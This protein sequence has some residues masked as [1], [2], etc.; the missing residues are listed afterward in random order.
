MAVGNDQNNNMLDKCVVRK[1]DTHKMHT[2]GN[3]GIFCM[4]NT[5]GCKR[6]EET[7]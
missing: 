4:I 5:I 6:E 2:G 7:Y 1:F 3:G